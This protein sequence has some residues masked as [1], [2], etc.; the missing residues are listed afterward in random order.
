MKNRRQFRLKTCLKTY[1]ILKIVINAGIFYEVNINQWIECKQ[2]LWFCLILVSSKWMGRTI[3]FTIWRYWLQSQ[4]CCRKGLL[5]NHTIDNIAWLFYL[6]MTRT[7]WLYYIAKLVE[8]VE[9]V[10]LVLQKKTD[11][12]TKIHIYHHILMPSVS[13]YILKYFAGLSIKSL[14][15]SCKLIQFNICRRKFDLICIFKLWC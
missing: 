13:L 5:A 3:Q 8:L 2:Q 10:F 6:Q 9:T 14:F 11:Q 4:F 12:I 1:N 15:R 7:F